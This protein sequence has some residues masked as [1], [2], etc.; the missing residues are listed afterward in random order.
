VSGAL[1]RKGGAVIETEAI[2]QG[3][4]DVGACIMTNAGV[5]PAKR[6]IHA[7]VMGQDLHTSADT[8]GTATRN[9]LNLAAYEHF[10]SIALP[11]LGT[12]VGGFPAEECAAVMID[13][14]VETLV[15]AKDLSLVRIV[16][17]D[18]ETRMVFT[19][20]LAHRF[21]VRGMAPKR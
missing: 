3:P 1:K 18:D 10:T 7:A 20:A 9:A 16:L 11:A 21:S 5:L 17:F 2:A 8:I 4:I 15:E 12:G 14:V 13:A 19:A 6:V